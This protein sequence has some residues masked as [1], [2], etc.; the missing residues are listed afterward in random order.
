MPSCPRESASWRKKDFGQDDLTATNWP[1]AINCP[2][3]IN[4][5]AKRHSIR[6]TRDSVRRREIVCTRVGLSVRCIFQMRALCVW[7]R[8]LMLYV[9]VATIARGRATY[10]CWHKLRRVNEWL[11][12]LQFPFLSLFCPW[13]EHIL[14]WSGWKN[15]RVHRLS[16]K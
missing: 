9:H 7:H 6:S 13:G 16:L 14:H 5:P 10:A 15:I 8:Q 1:C 2:W 4:W 11:F 3:A 12:L